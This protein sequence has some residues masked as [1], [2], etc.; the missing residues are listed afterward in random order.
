M[1]NIFPSIGHA[2]Q[3]FVDYIKKPLRSLV[4]PPPPPSSASQPSDPHTATQQ[5]SQQ[6]RDT[7]AQLRTDAATHVG[8]QG[9]IDDAHSETADG[10]SSSSEQYKRHVHLD[11]APPDPRFIGHPDQSHYCWALYNSYLKCMDKRGVLDGH[12]LYMKKCAVAMCPVDWINDWTTERKAGRWY[13][14]P[15]PYHKVSMEGSRAQY[16]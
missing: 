4:T 8:T 15:V 14:V 2:E 13:G 9:L 1:G 16:T 11:T 10:S 6:Q 7:L 3:Y 5:S 12:C